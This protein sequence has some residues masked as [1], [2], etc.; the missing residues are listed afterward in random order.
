MSGGVPIGEW[1]KKRGGARD[2]IYSRYSVVII[3]LIISCIKV[4]AP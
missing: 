4:C 3:F 2:G 1:C